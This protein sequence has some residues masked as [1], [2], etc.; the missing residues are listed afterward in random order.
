MERAGRMNTQQGFDMLIFFKALAVIAVGSIAFIQ[1]GFAHDAKDGNIRDGGDQRVGSPMRHGAM[2]RTH[3]GMRRGVRL[4]ERFDANDDG[5]LTQGEVDGARARRMARFDTDKDGRLSLKEFEGLWLDFM[6]ERMVDRFQQLDSDGDAAVTAQEFARPFKRVI[7]RLDRDGD[8][9][10][11]I[12]ELRSGRRG[13]G[14][15]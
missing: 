12:K 5:T 9:E 3:D 4:F 10:I 15:R 7:R 2:G 11:S 14:H 13:R 8:G 1:P 6:R